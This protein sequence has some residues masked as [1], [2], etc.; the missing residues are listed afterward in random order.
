MNPVLRLFELN[1]LWPSCSCHVWS[2]A[3]YCAC[4]V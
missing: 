2:V 4:G 3:L 1:K